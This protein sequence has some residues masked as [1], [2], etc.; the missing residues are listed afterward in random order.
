[1]VVDFVRISDEKC[2]FCMLFRTVVS[3][4]VGYLSCFFFF[5]LFI[6]VF[7]FAS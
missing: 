5:V 2:V 4:I 1:M 3:V 7:R 6:S